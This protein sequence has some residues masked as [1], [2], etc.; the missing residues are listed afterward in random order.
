MI[1]TGTYEQI[2]AYKYVME[3]TASLIALCIK[4]LDNTRHETQKIVKWRK[5]YHRNYHNFSVHLS[6][7]NSGA[8]CSVSNDCSSSQVLPAR[9]QYTKQNIFTRTKTQ[10]ALGF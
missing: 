2:H 9:S 5:T 3:P 4:L 10:S 7:A 6:P 8:L 1:I